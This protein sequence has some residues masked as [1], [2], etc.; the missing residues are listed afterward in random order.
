MRLLSSEE[1]QEK[2]GISRPTLYLW[3][4]QGKLHPRRAGRS[5]RFDEAEVRGLLGQGPRV[6][7]SFD[8]DS[9]RQRSSRRVRRSG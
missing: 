2:L 4:K 8:N 7:V 6:S 1:A 5:L 3:V 9:R